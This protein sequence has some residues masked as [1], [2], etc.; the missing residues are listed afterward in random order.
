M[1]ARILVLGAGFGGLE[2]TTLLSER[3]GARADITIIDKGDAFVFGY[4]KLD[5]MFG[6]ATLDGV[7]LPYAAFVKPGVGS[8]RDGDLDRSGRP[9]GDHRRGSPRVPTSSS[10]RSARTTTSPR[11]RGSEDANEFYSVAGA[12]ALRGVLPE[13]HERPRHRRGLRSA[14]QVPTR[15]ERVRP[16]AARLPDATGARERLRDHDGASAAEPG[17]ALARHVEGADRGLRRAQHRVHAEPS[18]RRDRR[19]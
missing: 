7:R 13:F 1:S 14:V 12:Q 17:A 5:V 16:P 9:P 6:R 19:R 3:L 4:S 15:A 10:S 11:R 18:H 8:S 2:L